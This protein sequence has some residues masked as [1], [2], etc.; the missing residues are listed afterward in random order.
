MNENSFIECKKHKSNIYKNF[1]VWSKDETADVVCVQKTKTGEIQF[2][3]DIKE[4]DGYNFCYP[5]AEKK[6]VT[7]ALPH[8]QKSNPI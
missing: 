1:T 3:K 7:A 2:P 6:R 4:I 5:F 8:G